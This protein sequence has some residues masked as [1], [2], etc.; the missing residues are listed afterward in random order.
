MN[1]DI[2]NVLKKYFNRLLKTSILIFFIFINNIIF[3]VI[4]QTDIIKIRYETRKYQYLLKCLRNGKHLYKREYK[5]YR[6]PKI[7]IIISFYNR[8][9][10]IIFISLNVN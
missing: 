5:K 7:S 2:E 9:K 4:T 10:F 8:G 3:R 1:S 6:N